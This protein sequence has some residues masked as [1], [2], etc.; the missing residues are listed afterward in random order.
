MILGDKYSPN[1]VYIL[2][3]DYDRTLMSAQAMLAGLFYPSEEEKWNKDIPWQPIPVHTAPKKFDYILAATR[4]CPKFNFLEEMFI[5][6]SAGI[7]SIFT[8]HS[9]L[10]DLWS[11]NFGANFTTP[12]EC[13]R[14]YDTLTIEKNLGMRFVVSQFK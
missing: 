1:K 3:T 11:T 12:I 9:N 4:D 8:E 10:F 5:S 14:L 2:S 7:K 13:Y 6:E